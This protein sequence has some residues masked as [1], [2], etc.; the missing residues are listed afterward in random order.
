VRRSIDCDVVVA[1]AGPA[2]AASAITL[3]KAGLQ[4]VVVDQKAFPRDKVCGDFV[5]PVAVQQ[6][7]VLG[8]ARKPAI[9]E[10]NRI[11]D[12][13][14]FLDGKHLLTQLVPKAAALPVS[15]VIPRLTLD[16]V[17]LER[18]R[19]TG[20]DI[21]LNC[22]LTSF[23][24]D[25][26]QVRV[27]IRRGN[28]DEQITARV[29]IGAD[30]SNSLVA[31]LVRGSGPAEDDR[32]IAV[33]GYFEAVEGPT[34]RADLYFGSASFPG[35]CWLFPAGDGVANVGIGVARNTL[36]PIRDHLR[37]QLQQMI[38]TDPALNRRLSQARPVGNIVGWPL[39]TYNEE[40]PLVGDR[41]LLV[42][43]AAGLI[44]PLNGEGIQYALLSGIWAGETVLDCAAHR[45]FSQEALRPYAE[46][47]FEDLGR[48]FSLTRTLVQLIRNQTLNPV[49][50]RALQVI[51]GRAAIDPE[52]AR[53]TGGVLAG[54]IPARKV[55]N[56][57]IVGKTVEH[58]AV[59]AGVQVAA[60]PVTVNGLLKA[61]IDATRI[62]IEVASTMLNDKAGSERWAVELATRA[63]NLLTA[64]YQ[65]NRMEE[66]HG[67]HPE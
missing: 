62:A 20:A 65:P 40:Q 53:V 50:L 48:D 57:D 29:L 5:S 47:V 54:T 55:I 4:V 33:R 34:D 10:S 56:P 30:G 39:T 52:Y 49:W 37:T 66:R 13:A 46:R 60:A 1:G 63:G 14:V 11:H 8:V 38:A 32:S 43:D 3:S 42:G 36:P 25:P 67:Q 45:D 21:R 28:T 59:R 61:G 22:R 12:A 15:R 19:S 18:A 35:Y 26:N 51:A 58:A 27:S 24:R 17:L 7:R 2:G 16:Q 64:S 44:N 9:T 31:R 6:L 41:T 23:E